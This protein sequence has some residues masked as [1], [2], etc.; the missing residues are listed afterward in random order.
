MTGFRNLLKDDRGVTLVQF[1]IGVA[2]VATI[3]A[4]ILD[5]L[6]PKLQGLDN[7]TSKGIRGIGGSGT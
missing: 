1:L 2:A 5:I 6:L 4:S 3:A 7:A